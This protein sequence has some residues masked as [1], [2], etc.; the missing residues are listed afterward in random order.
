[1]LLTKGKFLLYISSSKR[2]Y[3]NACLEVHFVASYP[4]NAKHEDVNGE[5]IEIL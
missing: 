4:E 1:M 3:I 5:T 2:A